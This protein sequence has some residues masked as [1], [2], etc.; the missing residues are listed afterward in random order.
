MSLLEWRRLAGVVVRVITPIRP[1]IDVKQSR[2]RASEF[3]I[4][5]LGCQRKCP[6]RPCEEPIDEVLAK[7]RKL[8]AVMAVEF[9][10]R[11]SNLPA[12]RGRGTLT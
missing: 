10:G 8:V 4:V 12:F 1:A 5:S 7:F 2:Y 3:W 6:K 9:L 11:E